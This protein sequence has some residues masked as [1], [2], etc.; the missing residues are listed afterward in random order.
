MT[1]ARPPMVGQGDWDAALAALTERDKTV[2]APM[3]ELAAARN[4]M[5]MVRVRRDYRF[6][7]HESYPAR[8][9]EP[10]HHVRCGS[11]VLSWVAL[12]QTCTSHLAGTASRPQ[13]VGRAADLV[14][15]APLLCG[16]ETFPDG[17]RGQGQWDQASQLHLF[18]SSSPSNKAEC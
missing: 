12:T 2:A 11:D 8:R 14:P 17:V 1:V 6:E 13:S 15:Q 4:R 5:P 7:A 18:S 3:H 16:R 9:R 10:R